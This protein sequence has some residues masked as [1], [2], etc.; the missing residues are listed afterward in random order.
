MYLSGTLVLEKGKSFPTSDLIPQKYQPRLQ[1]H[2]FNLKGHWL[3]ALERLI[4]SSHC[5]T[6][7]SSYVTMLQQATH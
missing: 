6:P 1:Y 2:R 3:L 7:N 4:E 5:P